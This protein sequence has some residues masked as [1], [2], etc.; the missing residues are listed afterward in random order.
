M[1]YKYKY[2]FST[3]KFNPNKN[4]YQALNLTNK[5]TQDEIKSAFYTLAKLYHPDK[6]PNSIDQFK[7]I[8]EA[9]EVL[10]NPTTKKDYDEIQV[11]PAKYQKQQYEREYYQQ[12]YKYYN[13]NQGQYRQ[14]YDEYQKQQAYKQ[15]HF[16]SRSGYDYQDPFRDYHKYMKDEQFDNYSKRN[17]DTRYLIIFM[18][19]ASAFIFFE[20]LDLFSNN[21]KLIFTDQITGQQYITT[22][23]ELR[24]K[25]YINREQQEFERRKT[26]YKIMQ[27]EEIRRIRQKKL[28]Q[29][30]E[31]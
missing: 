2:L 20:L 5:A 4:Y 17:S 7:A 24:S 21:K 29:M 30:I 3:L 12:T 13:Q 9:Y 31:K 16:Y 6:N 25:A 23:Q 8:N 28:E 15:Y 22:R 1:Y 19:A 11:N 26:E 18:M 10:K 14:A 27:Q